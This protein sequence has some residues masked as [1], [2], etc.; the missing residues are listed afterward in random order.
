M[1]L[2]AAYPARKN[3]PGTESIHLN[4]P[5]CL[6]GDQGAAGGGGG[7]QAVARRWPGGG[8]TCKICW[9][10]RSQETQCCWNISVGL[11][12]TSSDSRHRPS[13]LVRQR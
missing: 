11:S 3:L 2:F 5:L 12:P 1:F 6:N 10:L 8:L 13:N 7:G 9:M 4:V